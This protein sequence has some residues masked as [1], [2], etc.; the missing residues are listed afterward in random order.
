MG[1]TTSSI[2]APTIPPITQSLF[3]KNQAN[4]TTL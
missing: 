4:L 2:A 1:K 3:E